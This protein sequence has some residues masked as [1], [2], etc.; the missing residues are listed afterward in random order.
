MKDTESI[1]WELVLRLIQLIFR[2]GKVPKYIVWATMV[3][4]PKGK[5]GNR[6]IVIVEVLWKVCSVVVNFQLKRIS[7]F[8]NALHGFIEGIGAGTAIMDA[9]LSQ[10]LVGIAHDP[11]M[12]SRHDSLFNE[13]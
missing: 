5:G 9:N 8:H 7:V 6:G 2:D 3:L 10:Q 13:S 1:R 11:L 12:I 4:L